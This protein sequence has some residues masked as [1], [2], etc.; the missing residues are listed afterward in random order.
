[1][2]ANVYIRPM[3]EYDYK[4]VHALWMT[5]QGFGIRSVDDSKENITRFLRRN[6][7]TSIIA[8]AKGEIVGSILCGHDGRT[9][10]FYHVCVREDMR[11][12]GIGLAM[13]DAAIG[14]LQREHISKIS[15]FA[16]TDNAIGN[17]FW[18]KA[19]WVK[20]EDMNNY[21]CQLNAANVTTFVSASDTQ[22][23]KSSS[24]NISTKIIPT[25]KE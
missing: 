9:G 1:M 20:R 17:A 14:A 15:L 18:E 4:K 5:I 8:E 13:V 19:G 3:T 12:Q 21:E 24:L 22:K 11:R 16:F 2:K 10:C 6:P 23:E 25:N 7:S